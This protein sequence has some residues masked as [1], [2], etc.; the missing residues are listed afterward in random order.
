[1]GAANLSNGLG[2][3]RGWRLSLSKA[4]GGHAMKKRNMTLAVLTIASATAIYWWN[5]PGRSAPPPAVAVSAVAVS[6]RFAAP[7]IP[8]PPK[9]N[10]TVVLG[11]QRPET[12]NFKALYLQSKD[13]WQLAHVLLP[14]AKAGNRDAQYFLWKTLNFCDEN[15]DSYF[16]RL[17]K[18]LSLDE[19]LQLAAKMHANTAYVQSVYARC[20]EFLEVDAAA[21]ADELGNARDWLAEA[22]AEGQPAAEA[23]T[24]QKFV[25]QEIMQGFAN[26]GAAP[27]PITS[28]PQI[29]KNTNPAELMRAAAQSLDPDALYAIGWALTYGDSSQES[30]VTRLAWMYVACQ[31][32]LDCSN[33][34]DWVLGD[35]SRCI[36]DS[37]DILIQNMSGSYW[38]AVQRRAQDINSNLAAGR[39]DDLGFGP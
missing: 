8:E 24:A 17:G 28:G 30:L 39:W 33:N 20:H 31:R 10:S 36:A 25:L 21:L 12:K 13:Y 16:E 5:Q 18:N 22:T 14:D 34:A 37:P 27:I 7:P 9:E 29:D 19:G 26:A 35:C 4:Y 3:I 2:G 11:K 6:P 1:M 23:T 32:G 38:F 15:N